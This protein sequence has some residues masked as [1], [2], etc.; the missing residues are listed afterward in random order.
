MIKIDK[1]VEINTASVIALK[2]LLLEIP[3]HPDEYLKD[4]YLLSSLKSQGAIA[5]Y[6]NENKDIF[7]TSINTVKR[8][9]NDCIEGGYE[10]LD[11]YR[12]NALEAISR[13]IAKSEKSNKT[14]RIGLLKRVDELEMEN[15][16]LKEVNFSL[17]DALSLA[18]T[19][20][21]SVSTIKAESYRKARTDKAVQSLASLV[22]SNISPFNNF[23]VKVKSNVV[24]LDPGEDKT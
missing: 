10:K 15:L 17:L 21:K 2:D 19:E 5:K 11:S 14:T 24:S 22:S 13:H 1:R 16:R 23:P 12:I 18:V 3:K 9:S 6:S 20:I 8:I 7:A 4:L